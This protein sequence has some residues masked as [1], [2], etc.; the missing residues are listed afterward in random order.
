MR[1]ED[2]DK[3]EDA[4]VVGSAGDMHRSLDL[5]DATRVIPQGIGS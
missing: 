1:K 4:S 2:R 3:E 5:G